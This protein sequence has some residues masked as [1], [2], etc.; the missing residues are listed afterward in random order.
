LEA[1]SLLDDVLGVLYCLVLL[2]ECIGGESATVCF[3]VIVLIVIIAIC[4][5]SILR[6]MVFRELI[7]SVY[8]NRLG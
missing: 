5:I 6:A 2:Y 1:I 4:D 8:W 3:N 7:C